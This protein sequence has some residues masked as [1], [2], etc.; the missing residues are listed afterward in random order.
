MSEHV[1]ETTSPA[2]IVGPEAQATVERY[3]GVTMTDAELRDFAAIV[4]LEAGNQS[5]AGRQAVAEVILNRVIAGN[6]PDTI[7]DVLYRG[8][9]TAKPQFSSIGA[10]AATEP[11]QEHYDAIFAALRGPSILPADVVY[12]SRAGEND[13]VW[14]VIGDH[15]FCYQYKF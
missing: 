13:R 2:G 10:A 11:S 12:F 14:G 1:P 8:A 5:D 4:R 9:G 6:F 7:H 15:V 3:A